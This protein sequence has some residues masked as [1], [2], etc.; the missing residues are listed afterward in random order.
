[1]SNERKALQAKGKRKKKPVCYVPGREDEWMVGS[2]LRKVI[3]HRKAS[4]STLITMAITWSFEW[5]RN[6][7]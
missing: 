4:A 5:R 2:E 3:G 6:L 1:M 7:I